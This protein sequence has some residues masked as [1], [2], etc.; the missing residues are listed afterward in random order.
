MM[1]YNIELRQKYEEWTSAAISTPDQVGRKEPVPTNEECP[2]FQAMEGPSELS[3]S[4]LRRPK[5][6]KRGPPCQNLSSK[7]FTF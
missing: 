5:S 7:K 1:E 2:K 6:E 3:R 4:K